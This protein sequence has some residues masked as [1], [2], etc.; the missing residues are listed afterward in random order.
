[1]ATFEEAVRA[2]LEGTSIEID[3]YVYEEL[4]DLHELT[5]SEIQSESW[6]IKDGWENCTFEDAIIHLTNY[7]GPVRSLYDDETEC[8]VY[9]ELGDLSK[10]CE[11][12][13]GNQWQ[14]KHT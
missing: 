2:L 1:M 13:V 4:E 5:V 14:R 8:D 7:T 12:E 6:R 3:G 11:S 9:Q 10:L